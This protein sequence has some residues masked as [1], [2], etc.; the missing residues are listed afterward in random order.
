VSRQLSLFDTRLIALG[1]RAIEYR[2]A[3]RRRRTLGIAV[4][5]T[6]LAVCAPMRAPLRDI[7]SFL[8][9]KERWIIS[10]LDEWSRVPRPAELHV[11]SGE[12]LPL[13]GSELI[14]DVREGGRAVKREDGRLVVCAPGPLRVVETLVGWLKTKALE[15]LGPRVEHFAGRLGLPAPDVALSSARGQWGV[16]M[17]GGLIRLNWRLVHLAPALADYVAA[18]EAAHL[19]EMNH[20]K[21]FWGLVAG[22]YPAW[23]EARE[24][25]EI[26]GAAIP[27]IRGA[28]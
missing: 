1:G 4:D 10:K 2:F 16:C 8:R 5:A 9:D 28:R 12:T 25:L 13:L 26:A 3:R 27:I 20:S 6:G 24:E 11:E 17:E 7:E 21:R 23:R 22:L 18:H 14:L 15:T 19:V